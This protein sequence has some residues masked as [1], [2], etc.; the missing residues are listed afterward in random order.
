MS[1]WGT[2]SSA[3]RNLTQVRAHRSGLKP[4]EYQAAYQTYTGQ[5]I[6]APNETRRRVIT[7]GLANVG[8]L[9]VTEHEPALSTAAQFAHP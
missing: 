5:Q 9:D 7:G 2:A 6:T 8:V 1:P 4:Y 3:R